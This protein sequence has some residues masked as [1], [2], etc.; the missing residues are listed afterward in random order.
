ALG[1]V[2]WVEER[3]RVSLV[4]AIPTRKREDVKKALLHL[5]MRHGPQPAQARRRAALQAHRARTRRSIHSIIHGFCRGC[6]RT[7]FPA[8]GGRAAHLT[9]GSKSNVCSD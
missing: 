5:H 1:A 3:E 8:M 9:A 4:S 2:T 7:G 6:P